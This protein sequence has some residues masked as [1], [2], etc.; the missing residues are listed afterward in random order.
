[1]IDAPL[2][3][4]LICQNAGACSIR[5]YIYSTYFISLAGYYR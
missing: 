1:M 4:D 3:V 5:F 2:G